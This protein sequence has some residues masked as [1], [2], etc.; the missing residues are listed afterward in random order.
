MNRAVLYVGLAAL[1]VGAV[2]G[3]RQIAPITIVSSGQTFT[4][5]PTTDREAWALD[6]LAAVG[7]STPTADTIAFL[8]AWSQAEDGGDD[9]LSRFNPWNTSQPEPGSW[10]IN[11]DGVRGYPDRETGLQ[12]MV[13]TLQANHAGYADILA[14][15][16]TNDPQRALDGLYASPWGTN[17]DNVVMSAPATGHKSVVTE[18]MSI[19]A[20]FYDTGAPAWNG[21]IHGGNDYDAPQG[22]PV[23]MP[24]DCVYQMTGFYDDPGRY[25][26]YL[27]CH[28]MDGL[29]YY[30]G[31]LQDVQPFQ[32]GAVIPAGTLIGFTNELAHTHVQLRDTS[33]GALLDFAQ[34]YEEH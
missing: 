7:N 4:G 31:H 32:E 6:L 1:L 29:E 23:Y 30:S 18:A 11:S 17:A 28:L 33:S 8:V 5:A 22:S 25:G 34:Y 27:I 10:T 12:A 20:G 16:Q 14:G 13:E 26:Q 24:F 15:L 9:A 3:E 2:W 19:S 21:G